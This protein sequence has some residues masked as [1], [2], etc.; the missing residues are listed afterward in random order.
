MAR[1]IR[2][3]INPDRDKRKIREDLALCDMLDVKL[4][5]DGSLKRNCCYS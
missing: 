2:N 5:A 4:A 1:D 3:E